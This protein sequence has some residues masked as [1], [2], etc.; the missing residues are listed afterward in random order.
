MGTDTM[1]PR[2]R[3]WCDTLRDGLGRM[4]SEKGVAST[5]IMM[6]NKEG[7]AVS[8]PI[9]IPEINS[10]ARDT[11]WTFLHLVATA[12]EATAF[13]MGGECWCLPPGEETTES[14]EATGPISERPDRV[15]GVF[16]QV[17][18][19]DARS[20]GKVMSTGTTHEI[21]RSDDRVRLGALL[22]DREP[23]PCRFDG[24]LST[25]LS[26]KPP[27][28]KQRDAARQALNDLGKAVVR[29]TPSHATFH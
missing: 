12:V 9:D 10:P 22:Y 23:T 27:S 11:V 6:A 7:L 1:T 24:N 19:R 13:L 8:M 4:L 28:K 16:V 26:A 18:Y 29:A 5:W 21:D 17:Y 14:G 3:R 20:N 2:M 15:E 25:V